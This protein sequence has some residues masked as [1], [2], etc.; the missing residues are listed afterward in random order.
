MRLPWHSGL[1]VSVVAKR[2]GIPV[3]VT[4]K[5]LRALNARGLLCASRSGADVRYRAVADRTVPGSAQLLEAILWTFQHEPQAEETIFRMS[6]AFTHPRRVAIIEMLEQGSLSK[7]ELRMRIGMSQ[8]AAG[9]QL[10]K[11]ADRGFVTSDSGG[12]RR[13]TQKHPL[14]A[15]LARLACSG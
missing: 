10:A 2:M 12:W 13:V 9:R 5:Y 6:T 8:A 4:S 14:A 11:L 15:V 7:V 3:S 1:T